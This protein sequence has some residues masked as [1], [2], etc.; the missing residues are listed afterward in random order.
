MDL[1]F[2]H[3]RFCVAEGLENVTSA[4]EFKNRDFGD[5][6]GV[7]IMD[8]PLAGLFSRAVILIDENGKVIY[9]ER[10]GTGLR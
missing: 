3:N 7:R 1:P 4:S 8:G 6:Y 2:A 9:T 5:D 10:A